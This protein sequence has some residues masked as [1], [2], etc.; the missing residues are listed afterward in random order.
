MKQEIIIG[1]Q[2]IGEGH[3]CFIV[4]EMSGNHNMDYNR[5]KEIILAAKQAGAD[6]VK[7]Q[8]YTADT[9]TLKSDAP[10]FQTDSEGIWAGMTLHE[11]YEQAYTP[12]EWQPKLK[13]YAEEL[14]ILLFSSPFDLSSV[15]FLEEMDMPA[16]K[17]ASFEINDIPLIRRVARTGKPVIMSTG[18]AGLSDIDLAVQTCLEE[19]NDQVI[20]LKCTSAYPAPYSEMNLK[21][22]QNLKD[23]FQCCVGLSDHSMGDEVAI[24]G[25]SL[26]ACMVEKHLT[27]SRADGGVDSE[28]SMEKEEMQSMIQHIRHV[29]DA[30][31]QSSFRLSAKQKR[32]GE[33]GRSLFVCDTI[34]EGEIFTDKNIRSVRPGKGLHTKYYDSILGKKACRDL[35]YAKPLELGDID[36]NS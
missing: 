14:G 12:W 36:W 13:K 11:L 29:E 25:V 16:Y 10:Y 20:L 27:L 15:D 34:H 21:M 24:A 1:D 19:G 31:G 18:I 28:F 33:W 2:K 30:L 4:A 22:I 35:E 5:A 8:T 7:I 17:I 23:T 26:G 3:P 9:I 6:A 32:Q